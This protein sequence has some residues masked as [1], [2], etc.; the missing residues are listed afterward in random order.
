MKIKTCP[1]PTSRNTPASWLQPSLPTPSD[2]RQLIEKI[3]LKE[4]KINKT[5]LHLRTNNVFRGIYWDGFCKEEY[6][7]DIL[8]NRINF[9]NEF[10]IDSFWNKCPDPRSYGDIK[11]FEVDHFEAYK[12]YLGG[13]VLLCSNYNTPPP[14]ILYMQEYEQLYSKSA[15]TYLKYYRSINDA[16][17]HMKMASF[18]A[19]ISQP[20]EVI[21]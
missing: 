2:E 19:R 20:A 6:D 12:T 21:K 8:L 3:K 9:F 16:R 7:Q 1:T 13:V 17:Q 14:A 10:K 15:T 18:L 5:D 11:H 4:D